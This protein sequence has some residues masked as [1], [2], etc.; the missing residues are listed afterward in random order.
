LPLNVLFICIAQVIA[1]LIA[2]FS[3]LVFTIFEIFFDWVVIHL[4]ETLSIVISS[5]F[6]TEIETILT[7]ILKIS[8]N[9]LYACTGNGSLLIRPWLLY[10]LILNS[11]NNYIQFTNN[12]K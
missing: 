11:D 8:S 9:F 7:L 1:L 12:R 4:S 5:S 3:H 2:R 6:S 10:L